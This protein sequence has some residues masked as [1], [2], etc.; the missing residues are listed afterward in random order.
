MRWF[1][2]FCSIPFIISFHIHAFIMHTECSHYHAANRIPRY[3]GLWWTIWNRDSPRKPCS[4]ACGGCFA[5]H[6][7]F[8]QFPSVSGLF[9]EL[10]DLEAVVGELFIRRMFP[11]GFIAAEHIPY[12]F[13][14][15]VKVV[16]FWVDDPCQ[17]AIRRVGAQPDSLAGVRISD[18]QRMLVALVDDNGLDGDVD[19]G[20]DVK[21]G[22]HFLFLS[23]F[24][25]AWW[26][27]NTTGEVWNQL[28]R[29]A[30]PVIG[31]EPWKPRHGAI[32]I[33]VCCHGIMPPT[34]NHAIRALWTG[35]RFARNG[36]MFALLAFIWQCF[37]RRGG[38]HTIK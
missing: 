31:L 32:L 25:F 19:V 21:C 12:I 36:W 10:A 17:P 27:D 13:R 3:D 8:N 23:G 4:Y 16:V 37:V 26:F 11:F 14:G 30:R 6:S 20:V 7:E 15:S 24:R 38:L 2:F 1:N 18:E 33:T 34:C 35:M 29:V 9:I 28:R 22:E 5:V